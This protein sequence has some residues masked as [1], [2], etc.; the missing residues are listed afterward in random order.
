MF[1]AIDVYV[2]TLNNVVIAIYPTRLSAIAFCDGILF[3]SPAA[4]LVVTFN[5]DIIFVSNIN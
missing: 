1:K 4:R 5:T 2:V 3:E